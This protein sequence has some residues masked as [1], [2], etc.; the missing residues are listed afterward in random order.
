MAYSRACEVA[1]LVALTGLS[2]VDG[3]QNTEL[4]SVPITK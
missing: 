1:A 3:G 2:I 4:Y